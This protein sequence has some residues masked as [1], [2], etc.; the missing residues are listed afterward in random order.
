[1]TLPR[2][3]AVALLSLATLP[4]QFVPPLPKNPLGPGPVTRPAPGSGKEAEPRPDGSNEAPPATTARGGVG[5]GFQPDAQGRLVVNDL[6]PGG[7]GERAGVPLGA[8]LRAVDRQ[9]IDGLTFE[10]LR[11]RIQGPVGTTVVLTL[12]TGRE[13]LDVV[14]QRAQLGAAPAGGAAP[15]PTNG[16]GTFPAWLR[17]GARATYFAGTSTM[18]GVSTQL[19]PGDDGTWVDGNGNRYREESVPSTGGG[20]LNQYDFVHVAPDCVA[21]NMT[22]LV[23]ADAELRTL[24]RT[25]TVA[26][27]GDANGLADL[28]LP[29][30]KLRAMTEEDTPAQRVRR[31]QYPLLG[32]TFDAIVLQSKADSGYQRYTYDLDTGLLLVFSASMTGKAVITPDGDR[33]RSGAGA[34]TIATVVLRDLR[35]VNLPWADQRAPQWLR[36]GQRFVYSGTTRNS[37][38]EGTAWRTEFAVAP[39]RRF[40]PAV[41]A[42]V[43][44][45]VDYGAGQAAPI[46]GSRVYGPGTF[47]G[48]WLD[49]SKLQRLQAGAVLDRDP[50]TGWQ[51]S[52]VGSDGRHATIGEQGPLD[53]QTYTYDLQSGMLVATSSRQQ[54][55]PATIAVDLQ[56]AD[57]PR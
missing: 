22:T 57:G 8:I 11:D 27:V 23:Y 35:H 32:R 47:G 56:L 20:G 25:S 6:A 26:L 2:L 37:L 50:T 39:L 46:E 14:V 5:I 3:L 41:L 18:P 51:L 42:Q 10:Q 48:L 34:T 19:V 7:P 36:D 45:A 24:T 21:T 55:G 28:W 52:F 54:Q 29:P 1:M 9:P 30:A 4:A 38:V 44:S 53:Q 40:G 16:N 49:P 15:A 12:E 43:T 31:V 13:V 17:V 33:A